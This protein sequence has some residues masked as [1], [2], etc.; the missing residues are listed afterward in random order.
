MLQFIKKIVKKLYFYFDTFQKKKASA[1]KQ[2]TISSLKSVGSNI[3]FGKD[4]SI[5]N[6]KY[7]E[8]GDNFSAL[9]R[10]RIEAWDTYSY[11]TFTPTIKIGKNVVFNTDI[12]IGCINKI[13]IGDNCL[14]GSRIFITD[15]HHGEP[16]AE[17]LKMAPIDRPLVSKG[18]V[19]IKNNVW[20]GEG[21]AI[22]PGVTIGENSIIATNAVVTKDVPSN[23]VVAGVPALIIKKIN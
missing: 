6:P 15:H 20:V 2:A 10:F 13:I 23:C 7:I 17:M 4:Y 8:I 1:I 19:I 21:V 3:T 5:M 11:Q 18:A 14:F 22:M 9:D 12:H 16:T